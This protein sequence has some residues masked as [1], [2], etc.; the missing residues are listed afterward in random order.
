[1]A[2][3]IPQPRQDEGPVRECGISKE[4]QHLPSGLDA[5]HLV[6]ELKDHPIIVLCGEIITLESSLQ[7][8]QIRARDC[9]Q[10]RD[11]DTQDSVRLQDAMAF[12]HER[13]GGGMGQVLQ[14]VRM[15]DRIKVRGWKWDALPDVTWKSP[16]GNGRQVDI[17]PVPVKSSPAADV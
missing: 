12:R 9:L 13:W 14:E 17:D 15:V 16:G 8:L 6:E 7:G 3:F 2:G 11:N 1:M 10:V 4:F 5:D